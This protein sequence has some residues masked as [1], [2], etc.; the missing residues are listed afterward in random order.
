LLPLGCA[1][2][3]KLVNAVSQ[4]IS[5]RQFCDCCAPEREQAPSPQTIGY[6]CGSMLSNA[7]FTASSPSMMTC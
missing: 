4:V 5:A 1:A 3:L 7:R 2:A 6:C